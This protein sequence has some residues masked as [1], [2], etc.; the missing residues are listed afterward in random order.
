M[1]KKEKRFVYINVTNEFG[2]INIKNSGENFLMELHQSP[3]TLIGEIYIEHV[4]PLE[5]FFN[6]I[7]KIFE[8]EKLSQY[9]KLQK[10]FTIFDV[11]GGF[12]TLKEE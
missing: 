10:I 8:N 5:D 6:A 4:E 3:W 9:S 2:S 11:F 1:K 7:I 12:L